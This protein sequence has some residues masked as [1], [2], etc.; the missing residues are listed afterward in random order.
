MIAHRRRLFHKNVVIHP[1]LANHHLHHSVRST[2]KGFQPLSRACGLGAYSRI[3]RLNE[4]F[5]ASSQRHGFRA[6]GEEKPRMA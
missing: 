1:L 4:P 2:A 6:E 3:V 5:G